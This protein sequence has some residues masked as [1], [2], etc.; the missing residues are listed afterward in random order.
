LVVVVVVVVA[1]R[2]RKRTGP[3]GGQV[4]LRAL[5]ALSLSVGRH[6]EDR[7]ERLGNPAILL[8]V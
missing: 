3:D 1:V 4:A 6:H 8:P 2:R 5:R 7:S